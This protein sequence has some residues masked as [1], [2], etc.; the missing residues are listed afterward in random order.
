MDVR[1]AV[2]ARFIGFRLLTLRVF[3]RFLADPR[4]ERVTLRSSLRRQ[5]T[6]ADGYVRPRKITVTHRVSP[7]HCWWR[8]ILVSVGT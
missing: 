3:F 7:F 1:T 2:R 4:F 8:I 5:V 6:P